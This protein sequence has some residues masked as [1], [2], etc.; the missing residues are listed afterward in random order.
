[1]AIFR[2]IAQMLVAFHL[3]MEVMEEIDEEDTTVEMITAIEIVLLIHTH[4]LVAE[5][6]MVQIVVE[7]VVETIEVVIEI[8]IA[9]AIVLE[10]IEILTV[11]QEVVV[12]IVVEAMVADAIDTIIHRLPHPHLAPIDTILILILVVATAILIRI[13]MIVEDCSIIVVRLHVRPLIAIPVTSVENQVIL[14][15]IVP[16]K[17]LFAT[18]VRKEDTFQKTVPREL[19]DNSCKSVFCPIVVILSDLERSVCQQ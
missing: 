16:L 2:K 1:M 17:K 19:R 8:S 6:L 18:N 10:L 11:A 9:V 4:I 14:Q 7:E 3:W 13:T 12:V 15:E 5:E